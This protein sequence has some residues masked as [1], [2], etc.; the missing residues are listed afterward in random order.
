MKNILSLIFSKCVFLTIVFMSGSNFFLGQIADAEWLY[1]MPSAVEQKEAFC[2]LD[3]NG[4]IDIVFAQ[5]EFVQFNPGT[6]HSFQFEIELEIEK[7]IATEDFNNDGFPEIIFKEWNSF[8]WILWNLGNGTFEYEQLTYQL[9]IPFGVG[10]FNGDLIM[11]WSIDD[12]LHFN[13]INGFEAGSIVVGSTPFSGFQQSEDWDG[14][15]LLDI[16]KITNN[17]VKYKKNL[18]NFVY[19]SQEQFLVSDTQF[20]NYTAVLFDDDHDGDKDFFHFG[21]SVRRKQNLGNGNFGNLTTVLD[22]PGERYIS[23]GDFDNNGTLDILGESDPSGSWLI[24]WNPVWF[25]NAASEV[26]FNYET[27]FDSNI[28]EAFSPTP[29]LF[30]NAGQLEFIFRITFSVSYQWMKVYLPDA[31]GTQQMP[32]FLSASSRSDSFEIA[33]TAQ[34]ICDFNHDGQL[35]IGQIYRGHV[36][37]FL[38]NNDS[39]SGPYNPITLPDNQDL[40]IIGY[41]RHNDDLWDDVYIE[42]ED[43][44]LVY[45]NDGNYGVLESPYFIGISGTGSYNIF[46]INSD[47]LTDVLASK[48]NGYFTIFLNN[49]NG[50]NNLFPVGNLSPSVVQLGSVNALGDY[51]NNGWLDIKLKNRVIFQMS[52]GQFVNG[53]V[54]TQSTSS[55]YASGDFNE[56]GFVDVIYKISFDDSGIA[57]ND[58]SG[59]FGNIWSSGVFVKHACDLDLDGDLDLIYDTDDV[60]GNTN[61]YMYK[62]LEG[63]NNWQSV[64]LFSTPAHYMIDDWDGD[65]DDDF[66]TVHQGVYANASMP[67]GF[68]IHRNSAVSNYEMSGTVFVD[69]NSNG[70]FESEEEGLPWVPVY[71]PGNSNPVVYTN[72]AGVYK[73]YLEEPGTHNISVQNPIDWINT[74]PLE[75]SASVTINDPSIENLNFGRVVEN[76][77]R[78]IICSLNTIQPLCDQQQINW[79][80]FLNSGTVS[81]NGNVHLIMP[82]GTNFVNAFPEPISISNDTVS[83]SFSD[84]EAGQIDNIFCVVDIP[85][86]EALDSIMN[87]ELTLNISDALGDT[88]YFLANSYEL[89]CAYDPNMKEEHT[90]YGI[91]GYVVEGSTL[92]YTIHF[93]NTGNYFATNVLIEDPISELLNPSTFQQ[94]GSSHPVEIS[95]ND[96]GRIS[97]FFPEI[98]LPDSGSNFL[99]SQGFVRFRIGLEESVGPGS[100]IENHAEIIFDQ[101]PPIITNTS[102]NNIFDCENL[103]I[104][105]SDTLCANELMSL[106]SSR[107]D[108]LSYSWSI[109]DNI[110]P[111]HEFTLNSIFEE[112]I[113][114]ISLIAEHPLCD[115][116]RQ[117]QIIINA[118]PTFSFV[119]ENAVLCDELLELQAEADETVSWYYQENLIS[120]GEIVNA[121]EAGVYTASILNVCGQ[122]TRE[123]VVA[124]GVHP[125][126][127][128]YSEDLISCS[129]PVLISATSMHPINWYLDGT[130]VGSEEELLVS[131]S[132]Q[133]IAF[134]DNGCFESEVEIAVEILDL[135][136]I[137]FVAD[138]P[139][140]FCQGEIVNVFLN[141]NASQSSWYQNDIFLGSDLTSIDL[142]ESSIIQ[143]FVSNEYCTNSATLEV[144]V[145]ELPEITITVDTEQGQLLANPGFVNYQWLQNGSII[146]NGNSN[147]LPFVVG[148]I[149]LIVTDINGCV[150]SSQETIVGLENWY[151]GELQ[152]FPN[153]TADLINLIGNDFI[154]GK[155]VSIIDNLGKII[156][157]FQMK[158]KIMSIPVSNFKSG[159]YH[160]IIDGIKSKSFI[161]L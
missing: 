54:Q 11:D 13:S 53:P 77:H 15:G 92:D 150:G 108:F 8:V 96:E 148:L 119:S 58:G 144:A 12:T 106:T 22:V 87:Y 138:G 126:F 5:S 107:S 65:G 98:M 57:F 30:P 130:L 33:E 42:L 4:V 7:I 133:Y 113:Y 69:S 14:D 151:N 73:F 95:F 78:D 114:E 3:N 9:N 51:D 41:G 52:N 140:Q 16:Y 103:E 2:D 36:N 101:N 122:L 154:Y 127:D 49:G 112:G 136:L 71:L 94:I 134:I 90:G 62:N 91:E 125:E 155:E 76:E 18:G 55:V 75:I 74:S 68:C 21:T 135:P 61:V 97:F 72:E 32:K 156:L 37:L 153:P 146:Q 31:N 66:V 80:S 38:Q 79:I 56:D 50:Y 28:I 23:A 83:W 145:W 20:S 82:F 6:N 147:E 161:K 137:D 117:S 157:T 24:N 105:N 143:V 1:R 110:Q 128:S 139:L 100:I 102:I 85:G 123:V 131:E 132:G 19:A 29:Y 158:S 46:D 141:S 43:S 149:E 25:S 10:D 81:A 84:L 64:F 111:S 152:V 120:A 89:L 124:L 104:I 142:S 129:E 27:Y 88:S 86:V 63:E 44:I 40:K 109:N 59:V 99:L 26:V 159:E 70:V 34:K 45:L 115:V 118:A 17:Q 48:P 160:L 35:D 47:G 60:S 93:Q 67:A 39:V 121:T 116:N